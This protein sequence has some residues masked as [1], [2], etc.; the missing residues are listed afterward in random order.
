MQVFQRKS[1]PGRDHVCDRMSIRGRRMDNGETTVTARN[2]ENNERYM[3]KI[4]LDTGN[5]Y[6]HVPVN[7][8]GLLP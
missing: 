8:F 2:N 6:E 5:Y 7:C 1:V 3:R 4:G